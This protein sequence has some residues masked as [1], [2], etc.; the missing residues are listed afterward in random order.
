M[1]SRIFRIALFVFALTALA[2]G[3]STLMAQVPS[4]VEKAAQKAGTAVTD[5]W[6]KMK[7]YTQFVPE[8]ALDDSDIDVDIKNGAVTLNGTVMSAAGRDRAVAIAKATEGVKGVT[9]N[10]RIA[11]AGSTPPLM[12][13]GF[14]KARIYGQ[15]TTDAA[16][17]GSDVDVDVDNGVVSLKGTVRTE[18][19]RSRAAAIAKAAEGVKSV[20]NTLTISTTR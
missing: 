15:L 1:P 16:L 6:I 3:S 12:S 5:S 11:P 18:A 7:I 2:G 10:L 8:K 4:P 19:G 13:D 14:I 9:D 17:E 20:N